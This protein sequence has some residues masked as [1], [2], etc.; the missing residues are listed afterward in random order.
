MTYIQG[1]RQFPQLVIKN[2]KYVKHRSAQKVTYWKCHLY[3]SGLC[4]SRC[5]IGMDQ[6]IILRGPHSHS[7]DIQSLENCHILGHERFRLLKNTTFNTKIDYN[8]S[9][10]K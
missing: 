4:K 5:I 3:D 2:Y 10:N 1:P 6:T 7:S 8:V 9:Y